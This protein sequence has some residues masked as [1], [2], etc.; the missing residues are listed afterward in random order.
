MASKKKKRTYELDESTLVKLNQIV[1]VMKSREET[2]DDGKQYSLNIAVAEAIDYYYNVVVNSNPS[3]FTRISTS[4]TRSLMSKYLKPFT[5]A[6]NQL[7]INDVRQKVFNE[8]VANKLGI[9]VLEIE[10]QVERTINNNLSG[11]K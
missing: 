5:E 6:V 4:I 8:A 11:E 2:G 7:L 9:N 3:F 10:E 1:K